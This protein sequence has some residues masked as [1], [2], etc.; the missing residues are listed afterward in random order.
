MQ[1]RWMERAICKVVKA[2]KPTPFFKAKQKGK[3]N[4]K[5]HDQHSGTGLLRGLLKKIFTDEHIAE[6]SGQ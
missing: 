4:R 3:K 5:E 6:V 2:T 1:C